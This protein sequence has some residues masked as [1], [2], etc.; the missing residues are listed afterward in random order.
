LK[1][2]TN[3]IKLLI[4]ALVLAHVGT[5]IVVGGYYLLF[6]VYRPFTDTWHAAVS[7]NGTRHLLRNVYEGVLGGTLA[8]LVVWNHYSKTRSEALSRLD[9]VEFK[10]HIPNVKDMRGLSGWQ[11]VLLP[12]FVIVYAIP[13]LLVGAGVVWLIKHG[14]HEAV[15]LHSGTTG[16][17]TWA[18]IQMLWTSNYDQKL[19]G[20]FA[21]VFLGRRVMR[22]VA[23]DLQ[24]V[25]A[26]RRVRLG[27]PPRYYHPPNFQARV[28]GMSSD[29]AAAFSDKTGDWVPAILTVA[30]V[31]GMALAGFGY[32]VLAYIAK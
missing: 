19:I 11:L 26:S 13:G 17:S 29:G 24:G 7:D 1:W 31:A 3:K 30:I 23:D 18:H 8:Q 21:S 27:K 5:L 28:N 22:G 20:L 9:R 2:T 32:Y 10:L 4:A 12:L 15:L 6:E 25:F 16:R 14:L